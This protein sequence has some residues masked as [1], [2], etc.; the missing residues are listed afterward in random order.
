VV[1]VCLA[2][3]QLRG[4]VVD[5]GGYRRP[6]FRCRQETSQQRLRLRGLPD[7]GQCVV[8][9]QHGRTTWVTRLRG[10]VE[11]LATQKAHGLREP[12]GDASQHRDLL[13]RDRMPR[14]QVQKPPAVAAL[15]Q[16]DRRD[17]DDPGGLLQFAPQQTVRGTITE[18]GGRI[19]RRPPVRR[20]EVLESDCASGVANV[21]DARDRIDP[22]SGDRIGQRPHVPV[23]LDQRP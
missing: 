8:E 16:H 5:S 12:W 19:E 15:A 10:A 20:G 21:R 22:D 17:V 1:D 3:E 11:R 18:G 7:D 9:E 4:D 23:E 2:R 13:R 6:T 14:P